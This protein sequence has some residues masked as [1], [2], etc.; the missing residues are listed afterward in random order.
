[1]MI[2]ARLP[3][4]LR[5]NSSE[6]AKKNKKK[7]TPMRLNVLDTIRLFRRSQMIMKTMHVTI[8][9]LLKTIIVNK[10]VTSVHPQSQ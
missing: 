1:M 10:S 7:Q 9:T 8:A 6:T 2:K 5:D 3:S 4:A